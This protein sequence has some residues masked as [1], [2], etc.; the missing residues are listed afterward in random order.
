MKNKTPQVADNNLW[1]YLSHAIARM[2]ADKAI[3]SQSQGESK[4]QNGLPRL[5]HYL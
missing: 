2:S 3:L 4:V 5:Q 1:G